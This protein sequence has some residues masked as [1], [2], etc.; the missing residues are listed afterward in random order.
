M[1]QAGAAAKRLT[2][3]TL[4]VMVWISKSVASMLGS[5]SGATNGF[6]EWILTVPREV[7]VSNA[8]RMVKKWP[9]AG[10]VTTG[11]SQKF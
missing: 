7:G 8:V 6:V 1:F 4:S 9:V 3:L 5:I 11:S 2:A 10:I